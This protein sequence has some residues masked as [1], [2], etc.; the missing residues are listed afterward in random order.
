MVLAL[1]AAWSGPAIAQRGG[2]PGRGGP[3]R[4]VMMKIGRGPNSAQS[5]G[6]ELKA[7]APPW[8][9]IQ[10]Q[11]KDYVEMAKTLAKATPRQGSKE[12]WDEQTANFAEAA[13][14][15]NKA[16]RD[17]DL[18]A[19]LT[20]QD[21]L[22][23]S[24]KGCHAVHRGRGGPPGGGPPGGGP[25]GGGPPGGGPPGGGP[26]GGGPPGGPGG[27]GGFGGRPGQFGQGGPGGGPGGGASA[28]KDAMMKIGRGPQSLNTLLGQELKSGSP[29]W[30]EIQAQAKEYLDLA[31][32]LAKQAPP[33]GTKESWDEQ[34]A[35][36]AEA[37][38]ALNKAAR[39]KDLKAAS[40]AH[41]QLATSCNSC[42]RTHRGGPGGGGPPGGGFGGPPGGPGGSP[43]GRPGQFG[44]GQG[45]GG[46]GGAAE[47]P[48]DAVRAFLDALKQQDPKALAATF[49]PKAASE[50]MVS[51]HKKAVTSIVSKKITPA[52]LKKFAA[53]FDGYRIDGKPAA[54]ARGKVFLW[55]AADDGR[56]K[57][58]LK[59]EED[60][61]KVVD[62]SGK[63]KL[64]R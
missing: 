58:Y 42:H 34:T 31:K 46:P 26:P 62:Y 48:E 10:D 18:K 20:A 29:P 11:A 32:S 9:T 59:H 16:A 41:D 4:D 45:P 37:A 50:L 47:S 13:E 43:G 24:C 6:Q 23:N 14:A 35:S 52:E 12:S 28:I 3:I 40:T 21:Q 8:K 15:L 39:D 19:A 25:P 49:S 5:I 38:E 17:K 2:P 53:D 1:V 30:R 64:A 33:K 51:S 60:G 22:A 56:R 63:V 44:P 61:W 55:L 7:D 57:V 54:A 36:F 27:P